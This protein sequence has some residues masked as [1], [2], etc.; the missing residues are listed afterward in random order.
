MDQKTVSQE[1]TA[2]DFETHGTATFGSLPAK[3]SETKDLH[4]ARL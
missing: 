2:G 3:Y 1:D 4:F